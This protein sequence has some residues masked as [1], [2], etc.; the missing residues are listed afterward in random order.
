MLSPVAFEFP[1][2]S[3]QISVRCKEFPVKAKEFPITRVTG[4]HRQIPDLKG[5]F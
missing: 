4:M 2:Y 3:K 1:V 5:N